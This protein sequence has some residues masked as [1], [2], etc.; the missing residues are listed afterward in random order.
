MGQNDQGLPALLS[1]CEVAKKLRVSANLVRGLM[2]S[3]EIPSVTLG[4]RN[5]VNTEALATK[6]RAG[7]TGAL[8]G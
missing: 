3:G 8:N 7:T 1:A 2:K 4:G 6:I 5:Y